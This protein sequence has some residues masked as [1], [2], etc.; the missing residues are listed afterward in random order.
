M[1]QLI[2]HLSVNS[3]VGEAQITEILGARWADMRS[4]IKAINLHSDRSGLTAD[5]T[6]RF[7]RGLARDVNAYRVSIGLPAL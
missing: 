2:T 5:L 6:E 7:E 1:S 3:G 4:L